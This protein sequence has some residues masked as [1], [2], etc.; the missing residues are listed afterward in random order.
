MPTPLDPSTTVL[1]VSPRLHRHDP[2]RLYRCDA[3][4]G[5]LPRSGDFRFITTH[6]RQLV[7]IDS[8]ID[9]ILQLFDG[10][11]DALAVHAA[12]AQD[13]RGPVTLL[14]RTGTS[15]AGPD[16][17]GGPLIEAGRFELETHEYDTSTPGPFLRL[18]VELYGRDVLRVAAPGTAHGTASRPTA[19]ID[20]PSPPRVERLEAALPPLEPTP[21]SPVLLL[22]STV[23]LATAGLLYLASYLRRH[24]VEARC[25]LLDEHTT[26]PGLEA[27]VRRLLDRHRPRLVG[28]SLKWFP[29]IARA[30]EICRLVKTFSP[31]TR[32]VL[33]GDTAAFFS[34]QVILDGNVDHVVRGDGELPLSRLAAGVDPRSVPN[35]VFKDGGS[36]VKTAQTYVQTDGSADDLRLVPLDEIVTEPVQSLWPEYALVLVAKGCGAS[37]FYCGGHAGNQRRVF[38]RHQVLH[39]PIEDVRHDL[40]LLSRYS[41]CLLFD[42]DLPDRGSVGFFE[43]L[44]AGMPLATHLARFYLWCLPDDGLVELLART[45]GSVDLNVDLC[46]LSERHRFQLARANLVKPQ[47]SDADL[48]AFLRAC[49]RHDNVGASINM[50]MGLPFFTRGDADAGRAVL[51]HI[52][53]RHRSLRRID[54]GRLHSQPGAPITLTAESYGMTSPALTYEEYLRVSE[55]NLRRPGGYPGLSDASY[56]SILYRDKKQNGLTS[57]HYFEINETLRRHLE[58]TAKAP[59][60]RPGT[61]AGDQD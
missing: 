27:N 8:R 22:G 21:L 10:S 19:A 44:F 43:E 54:W 11:R 5:G 34:E 46:S 61:A 14:A 25:Q 30:L 13:E 35:L 56:P 50:I 55:E 9:R 37:C 6:T 41:A 58:R 36:V 23:G 7:A 47:A 24:G 15:R 59:M 29:H 2:G 53:G 40:R 3:P 42:F 1:T 18:V 51:D 26:L 20:S 45:F 32:T 39:R 38:G 49:D 16:A 57:Q 48:L 33:G 31:S 12:L 28:V 52:I 4:P 60:G 17:P